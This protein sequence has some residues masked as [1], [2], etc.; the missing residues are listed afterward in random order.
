VYFSLSC[1]LYVE[2]VSFPCMVLTLILL[3]WKIGWAHNNASKWQMGYNST[4]NGLTNR[5]LRLIGTFVQ[6]KKLILKYYLNEYSASLIL[7]YNGHSQCFRG[8]TQTCASIHIMCLP[9]FFILYSHIF[10]FII[11]IFKTIALNISMLHNSI[12]ISQIL[13]LWRIL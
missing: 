3:T 7:L 5:S 10:L 12:R 1:D 4:F 8:T 9:F 6:H 13:I 11:Y 2:C